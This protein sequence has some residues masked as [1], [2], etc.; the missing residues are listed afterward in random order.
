M[1][2]V[3]V[4]LVINWS[5]LFVELEKISFLKK[6]LTWQLYGVKAKFSKELEIKLKHTLKHQKSLA[7][8]DELVSSG[9]WVTHEAE[10]FQFM[11]EEEE[12]DSLSMFHSDFNAGH[13]RDNGML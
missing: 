7:E 9:D 10:T 1:T 13:L 5:E 11:K 12:A 3:M 6:D 8:N 4:Q 2:F